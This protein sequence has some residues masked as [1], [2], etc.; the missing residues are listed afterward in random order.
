LAA[1]SVFN[2]NS[3]SNVQFVFDTNIL[4]DALTARGEYYLALCDYASLKIY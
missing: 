3:N 4:V 2:S 1:K